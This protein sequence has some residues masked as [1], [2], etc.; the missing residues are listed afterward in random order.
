M[1]HHPPPPPPPNATKFHVG[2]GTHMHTTRHPSLTTG[3][4]ESTATTTSREA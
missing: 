1:K 4:C 3:A 2:A